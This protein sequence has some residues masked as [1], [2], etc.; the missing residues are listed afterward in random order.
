MALNSKPIL[1]I[2]FI[3]TVL[4]FAGCASNNNTRIQRVEK[5]AILSSSNE[6]PDEVFDK[7]LPPM[8]GDEYE[9]LGDTLLSRGKLHIAYL[10]YERSLQANP[11][12]LRA[13]YKKGLALLLGEK[14]DEAIR[15]FE[16]VLEKEPR[17]A[18]AYEG[19]GRALFYK[20]EYGEA[21][22]NFQKA[23]SLNPALWKAHNFLGN[24]YDFQK[25]FEKAVWAYQS[26]LAIKPANGLLYNNLGVSYTLTGEFKKAAR[27]FNRAIDLKYATSKVY[28]NLGMAY[29]NLEECSNALQAFKQ[30]GG[31]A[32]ANNSLGCIYL[33]KGMFEEAVRCFEKA[34]EIEPGFYATANENL[35]KTR[36][37]KGQL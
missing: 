37:A 12:N 36:A 27:A 5:N 6:F 35:K 11:S 7:K 19:L 18:M 23:L 16:I 1:L 24:I 8:T 34:I 9:R 28:N 30:G 10:Q 25:N 17:F 26:A 22:I 2:G 13:E 21:E 33:K 3:L 32:R 15:Q 29:A 4:I 14:S 20:K 31:N